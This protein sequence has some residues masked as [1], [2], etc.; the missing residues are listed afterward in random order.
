VK[1]KGE[2]PG[3]AMWKPARVGVCMYACVCTCSMHQDKYVPNGYSLAAVP[4]S[5]EAATACIHMRCIT[6]IV[7]MNI[8]NVRAHC[9]TCVCH[10]VWK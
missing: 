4:T 8:A 2:G 1:I 6:M 5:P 10:G 3:V 7:S 9:N